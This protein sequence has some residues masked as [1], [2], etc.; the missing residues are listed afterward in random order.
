MRDP[1]SND[2][3]QSK[4]SLSKLD[5]FRALLGGM[6]LAATVAL[7]IGAWLARGF[8]VDS[9]SMA[10]AL[11]GPHQSLR[12]AACN[13]R[14]VVGV[15]DQAAIDRPAACPNCGALVPRDPRQNAA[16]DSVLVDRNAFHFRAPRRFEV[17]A[18]R[19]PGQASQTCVKRVVGLPGERVEVREGDVY[20]DGAIA[21]KNLA[22]QQ[23]VALLVHDRGLAV[24]VSE[25]A[26]AQ[27]FSKT[28]RWQPESDAS[29]WEQSHGVFRKRATPATEASPSTSS[30]T[31][32]LPVEDWLAYRHLLRVGDSEEFVESPVLDTQAYNQTRPV[33]DPRVVYDLMLTF[34][35][36]CGGSGNILVLASDGRANYHIELNT[37]TGECALSRADPAGGALV[38]SKLNRVSSV[39]PALADGKR[40]EVLIS[41]IDRQILAAIDGTLIVEHSVEEP[42]LG[43]P[44]SPVTR[45]FAIDSNCADLRLSNLRIYRDIYYTPVRVGAASAQAGATKAATETVLAADEFFVLSDNSR[46]GL[47]SR[48]AEFGPAAPFNLFVGKPLAAYSRSSP[49]PGWR[50]GIQVPA[51]W[52]FRYIR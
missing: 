25:E 27:P 37:T 28:D 51:P 3:V 50:G 14:F 4:P 24:Q 17:V 48:Y 35:V 6:V 29:A 11:L 45:P 7:S 18:L 10:T 47:D 21:R 36:E 8:T 1:R 39:G 19:E 44:V 30:A 23:A 16:G 38:G 13:A 22:Q 26:A 15:E 43:A 31:S 9:G 33:V 5:G 46:L 41:M 12:C 20:I 49:P 2:S 32:S 34:E 42:D 40:H 52:R